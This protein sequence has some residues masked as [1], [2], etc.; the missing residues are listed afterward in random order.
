[1]AEQNPV[2]LLSGDKWHIVEDSRRSETTLCGQR[3][4]ERRAH[5]R[6]SNV[7]L[8]RICRQCARLRAA[9]VGPI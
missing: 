6:L 4:Q 9:S 8:E 3:I 1:M 7:G 2:L 5:T